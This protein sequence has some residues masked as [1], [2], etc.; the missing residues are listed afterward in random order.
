MLNKRAKT[1]T[2]KQTQRLLDH[3]SHTRY[4]RLPQSKRDPPI[5]LPLALHGIPQG[6]GCPK[7][8]NHREPA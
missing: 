8:L 6:S 1:L 3:L 7:I 4:L 5:R 2:P